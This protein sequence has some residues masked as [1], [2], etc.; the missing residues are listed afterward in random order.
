MEGKIMGSLFDWTTESLRI[1]FC[2]IEY[3]LM[4]IRVSQI[5]DKFR[6]V[7]EMMDRQLKVHKNWDS[8]QSS[9]SLEEKKRG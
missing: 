3:E 9:P 4:K 8:K 7:E 2:Q 1:E 6:E 5:K